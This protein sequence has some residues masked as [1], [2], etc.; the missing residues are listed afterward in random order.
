MLVI[1]SAVRACWCEPG[2]RKSPTS[3]PNEPNAS[4]SVP[5][6]QV[7]GQG[8]MDV[9]LSVLKRAGYRIGHETP[10]LP[11][12]SCSSPECSCSPE[13]VLAKPKGVKGESFSFI[14]GLWTGLA[15]SPGRLQS[16]MCPA[17]QHN[18]HAGMHVRLMD[19]C[20]IFATPNVSCSSGCPLPPPYVQGSVGFPLDSCW[21]LAARSRPLTRSLDLCKARWAPL[22][23]RR[24]HSLGFNKVAAVAT[25]ARAGARLGDGALTDPKLLNC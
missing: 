20:T 12:A 9:S 14:P 23:T 24:R 19:T 15:V 6:N 10:G 16:D 3:F 17:G 21:R 5:N 4:A 2:P 7:L 1:E 11:G 18:A 22:L 25:S 13:L 8:I